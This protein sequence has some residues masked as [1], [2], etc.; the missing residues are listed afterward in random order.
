M[1]ARRSHCRV[2]QACPR[3]YSVSPATTNNNTSTNTHS[4][5]EVAHGDVPDYVPYDNPLLQQKIKYRQL[6]MISVGGSIGTGLFVGIS[7]ALRDGGPGGI[8]IA[9]LL[10]GIMLINVSC[11]CTQ[12]HHENGQL[13]GQPNTGHPSAR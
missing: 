7:G 1:D 6:Q 4:S 10:M 2:V 8:F 5:G 3:C 13:T 11:A 9:W 12:G